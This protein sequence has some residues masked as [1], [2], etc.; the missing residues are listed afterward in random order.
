MSITVPVATD[1]PRMAEEVLERVNTLVPVLHSRAA[2]TD[3]LRR[4][5]P[6]NLRDLTAAGVFRLAM[7]ADVGG[8]QADEETVREVLA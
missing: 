5:H 8:Y 4:M 3:T 6:D 7:P 2:A 1:T